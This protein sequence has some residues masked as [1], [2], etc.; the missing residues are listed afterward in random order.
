MSEI[1]AYWVRLRFT[2]R[3]SPPTL[4]GSQEE[5][6]QRVMDNRSTLAYVSRSIIKPH[7]GYS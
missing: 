3:A 6:L 4:V 7:I 2:G 1:N 5:A